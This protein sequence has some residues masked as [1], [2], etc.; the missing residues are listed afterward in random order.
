MDW[1]VTSMLYMDQSSL[2]TGWSPQSYRWTK[3]VYELDGYPKVVYGPKQ[4]MNWK[5]SP[6]SCIWTKAVYELDGYPKIVYGP[7]QFMNWKWSHQSCIWTKAVYELEMVTPK[8]YMD[9][10]SL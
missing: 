6:Q 3:A 2:W 10:S 7:K 5:W 9:Q 8:L 1:V 4:F